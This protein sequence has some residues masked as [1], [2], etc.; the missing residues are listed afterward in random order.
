MHKIILKIIQTSGAKIYALLLGMI[1]L[2]ITARYLEPEG[3]GIVATIVTWMTFLVELG[4]LSLS[5]AIVYNATENNASENGKES[6]LPG[7]LGTLGF[8]TFFITLLSWALIA[9]L[10]FGG[11]HWNFIPNV[12]EDT[13]GLPLL[14]GFLIMPFALWGLFTRTLLNIEDRLNVFNKYQIIGSTSNSIAVVGLIAASGVGVIG[15]LMARF[16][17]EGIVALGG[18]KELLARKKAAITLN[19]SHYK[20]LV[21]KGLKMHMNMVGAMML[22]S[23]DIIMV[24]SYL[25]NEE[26]GIYQLA[27]QTSLMMMIVPYSVM[28]VL[29]GEVTRKGVHG[30]WPYQKK[31]LFLTTAF[32]IISAIITGLTAKWWLL[33]LAG[34]EFKQAI[35]IF[36]YLLI[37]VIVSTG[38]AILSVQWIARGLFLQ[39]STA[40]ILT[41]LMNIGLNA[42][43]IPKYGI[44]GAVWATLGTAVLA[45]IINVG[46]FI[47]VERDVRRHN[48][49]ETENASATS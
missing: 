25:G 14:V 18:L 44:M 3:R 33:W 9:L 38:T 19:F 45:F 47:W 17:W 15:V 49:L 34:E 24:S 43:F 12:F 11:H 40:S 10:Y 6:L 23:I 8:H 27:V 46:M 37:W 29:Q 4:E 7:M 48:R 22:T 20:D 30:V 32:I 26:T 13:P 31:L 28:T 39:L 5:G 2:S 35:T 21:V 16:L 41:G 1:T 42:A 36:Q